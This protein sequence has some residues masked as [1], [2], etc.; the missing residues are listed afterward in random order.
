MSTFKRYKKPV[1]NDGS[2]RTLIKFKPTL[3]G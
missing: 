1:V 2:S 3:W